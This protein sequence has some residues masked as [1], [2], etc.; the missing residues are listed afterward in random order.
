M[1]KTSWTRRSSRWKRIHIYRPN[2]RR[3]LCPG[4]CQWSSIAQY[5]VEQAGWGIEWN[6]LH[7]LLQLRSS[8]QMERKGHRCHEWHADQRV[9]RWHA[10]EKLQGL[11]PTRRHQC[12]PRLHRQ[13]FCSRQ[14]DQN[15][16]ESISSLLWELPKLWC[17]FRISAAIYF[18]ENKL[19]Q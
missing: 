10:A 16:P 2:A 1:Y 11:Q 9:R 17:I 15:K 3:W 7:Q 14:L 12:S 8:D 19:T 18:V 5:F 13:D 4:R 6:D